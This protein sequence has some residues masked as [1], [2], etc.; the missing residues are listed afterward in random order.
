MDKNIV[1]TDRVD[2]PIGS[3]L[4]E[5]HMDKKG[6]KADLIDRIETIHKEAMAAAKPVALYAPFKPD[7]KDDVIHIN[8][9]E[10]REPFVYKMLSECELVVPYVASCGQEMDEWSQSFSD[11]LFE[12]FV[13]DAIKEMCLDVIRDKLV[14]EVQGKYFDSDKSISSI[15]PGSLNKWPVT[16]Q[17]PLF[18]VLGG[19][20]DDIGVELASSMMMLPTKSVSGIFFQKDK[21]FHNCQLCPRVNCPGRK[22]P[23]EGE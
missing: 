19:V 4:S 11:N 17:K 20:T 5:L 8:G 6:K 9:I 2:I 13:A 23:Y 10:F 3:V 14:A 12:R 22:A 1:S 7:T 16:G 21:E 18:S 15:N